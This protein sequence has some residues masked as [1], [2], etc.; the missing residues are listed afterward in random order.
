M[1]TI[2]ATKTM[3]FDAGH[4]LSQYDGKC[5][6]LHGHTYKLEITVSGQIDSIGMVI[7][8]NIIKDIYKTEVEPSFD[9]KTLLN[10]N[11]ELNLKLF[12]D[13]P[14]DWITWVNY[15]PTAENIVL[16]IATILYQSLHTHHPHITLTQVV[17]WETPTSFA[18]VNYPQS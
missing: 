9:H 17:L 1:T 5:F 6:K 8:F 12:K 10:K 13:V 16:D 4:R 18:T 7:D 2:S 3:T 11:D 15:N 14:T